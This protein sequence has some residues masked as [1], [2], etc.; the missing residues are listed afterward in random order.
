V[1]GKVGAAGALCHARLP[2][3]SVTGDSGGLRA[4]K[5]PT[6]IVQGRN[7]AV[8]LALMLLAGAEKIDVDP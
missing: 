5:G 7:T 1:E 3:G 4:G 8:G 6:D 2:S